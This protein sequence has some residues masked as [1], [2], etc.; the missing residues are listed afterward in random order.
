M[1]ELTPQERLQPSLLDRL[2]DD[3]PEEKLESRDKR[4]LSLQQM[5]AGVL[6][7]LEWLLNTRRIAEPA[8]EAL[9][10]VCSSLYH[11]GI[12]DISSMSSDSSDVRRRLLRAVEETIALYEPRLAGARAS[13]AE[14]E[15]GSRAVHFVIEGLLRMDPEPEQVAFDTVLELS[16]GQ[17]QV[18][19]DGHA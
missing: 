2:V 5:R 9:S 7:D 8:P 11:Y 1:A 10:E 15:D 17:F 14:S 16:S 19:G 18:S 6:R 4:V 3:A 12:P 13:I